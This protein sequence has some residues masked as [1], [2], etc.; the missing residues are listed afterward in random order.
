MKDVEELLPGSRRDAL[1]A[2]LAGSSNSVMANRFWGISFSELIN[3][4][5]Q[6]AVFDFHL[7]VESH[8]ELFLVHCHLMQLFGLLCSEEASLMS[9][10]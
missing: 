6:I 3:C 1:S 9:F 7:Q 8:K 4:K 2:Y 10:F 5:Y